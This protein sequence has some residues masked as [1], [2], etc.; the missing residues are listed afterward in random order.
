MAVIDDRPIRRLVQVVLVLVQVRV[1]RVVRR[2]RAVSVRMAVV[3]VER[4]R[5]VGGVSIRLRRM[6]IAAVHETALIV[7]PGSTPATTA[8]TARA[9]ANATTHATAERVHVEAA[10]LRQV[11]GGPAKCGWW[12]TFIDQTS[13]QS[14][15]LRIA[16]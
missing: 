10:L 15:F 6:P 3:A 2:V 7:R 4:V 14:L 16:H 1:R 5:R 12:L 8:H 13:S 11:L 9:Y